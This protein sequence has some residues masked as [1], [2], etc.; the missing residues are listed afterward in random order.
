MSFSELGQILKVSLPTDF[1]C[2]YVTG[3]EPGITRETIIEI[4]RGFGFNINIDCVRIPRGTPLSETRA[5]VRVEDPSFAKELCGRLKQETS[6]LCA[7]PHPIDAWR[8][9]S[10]KLYISWHKATRSVWLKYGNSEIANRVAR[11]FNGDQ[12]R[13]LGHHVECSSVKGPHTQGRRGGFSH[14]PVPWTVV[15]SNVPSNTTAKDVEDGIRAS[16]DRP[17]HVEL[18]HPSYQASDPEV[19]VKVRSLLVE[20]GQ[21][22]NFILLPES[23][24]KRVKAVSWFREEADAI[25]ACSLNDTRLSI[26]GEGKL[27][28]ALVQSAKIKVQTPVYL[29]LRSK[30][31]EEERIWREHHLKF[32]IYTNTSQAF[33]T[34]KVEGEGDK[35]NEVA[36]AHKSLNRI[37]RGLILKEGGNAIWASALNINGSAHK[38]VKAIE[39]ELQILVRRDRSKRQLYF[40][41]PTE[42][43][44]QAVAHISEALKEE[45][46]ASYQIDLNPSQFSRM[47]R[48]GFKYLEQTLGKNVAVLNVV[49]KR[50]TVGGT[51]HQY[52]TTLAILNCEDVEI[53]DVSAFRSLPE[54]DCPICFCEAETPVQTSC[55]HTYCLECFEESCKSAASTSKI[56]FQVKCQGEGGTCSTIF[57]LPELKERLSSTVFER[58]LESSFKEYLQR[59]PETFHSCPTTD[60]G[61]IYR[62]TPAS[63]LKPPAYRCPNCFEPIC[64]SC[65]EPHVDYTCAEYKDFESGRHKAL[66]ELKREL[67]IKDCPKC[68]T[69][70]EKTEGCNH[71]ICG[72]CKSHLCWVCMEVF[73]TEK[74]CYAHLN[75]VH[76]GHGGVPLHLMR[77]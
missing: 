57:T 9:S 22:E 21:L 35:A 69:P 8:S 34:L 72:A 5:L 31:E 7:V 25:S 45:S 53:R 29:A 50:L 66:Q 62:C 41:G 24:G 33:T 10:K 6:G 11:K 77:W 58:V 70:I 73:E 59:H 37:L 60:C 51:Q 16:F 2:A 64:T 47:I 36:R 15:L 42:K 75:K 14:N 40:Y 55:K 30:I 13:V 28:V 74:A 54:G 67:N 38:K 48:G 56:K 19:S 71:M 32:H 23:N 43:Y 68:T 76:G 27:T 26:L 49:L 1:S 12:Y 3:I 17:R 20:Y 61:Y 4:L 63:N 18:G 44:E 65:H 39:K 52:Q 46:S